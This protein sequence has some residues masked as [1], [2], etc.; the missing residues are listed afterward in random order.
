MKFSLIVATLNRNN[1]LYRLLNSLKEQTYKSFDVTI[2]DQNN[3]DFLQTINFKE[4]FGLNDVKVVKPPVLLCASAAR[5]FGATYAQGDIITFPDDDCWY[6]ADILEKVNNAFEKTK[7]DV[8]AGGSIDPNVG[9]SNANF[10]KSTKLIDSYQEIPLAGI[11]YS[12]FMAKS[13][14]DSLRFDENISP[15]SKGIY[16]AGEIT[17]LL[18]FAF[19]KGISIFYISDI[20]I[21]HPFKEEKLDNYKKEFY[22]AIGFGYVIKKHGY[23]LLGVKYIFRSVISIFT[24]LLKFDWSKSLIRVCVTF[25]RIVGLLSYTSR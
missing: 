21:Y 8:I 10:L 15:G 13:I 23:Y 11:E 5:N 16:Q 3:N 20:V 7:A 2:V 19:K 14:F 4:Q 9:I 12:V 1:D 17:D 24:P 25:G 18:F 6:E 22:Y